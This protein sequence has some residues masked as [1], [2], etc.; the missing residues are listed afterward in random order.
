M[1]NEL[2]TPEQ[3]KAHS[4]YFNAEKAVAVARREEF[5]A[6]KELNKAMSRSNKA[7]IKSEVFW[8]I[9]QKIQSNL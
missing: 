1:K 2:L 5:E 7:Q 8:E 9:W 6:R 3:E 4:D